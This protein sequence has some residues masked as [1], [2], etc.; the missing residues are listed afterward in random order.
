M[1][2]HLNILKLQQEA[3]EQGMLPPRAARRNNN[4]NSSS[5]KTDSS[6]SGSSPARVRSSA[7]YRALSQINTPRSAGEVQMGCVDSS[8]CTLQLTAPA[9]CY[10]MNNILTNTD[11]TISSSRAANCS[12]YQCVVL[13]PQ[14]LH[15]PLLQHTL[16]LPHATGFRAVSPGQWCMDSQAVNASVPAHHKQNNFNKSQDMK[17]SGTTTAAGTAT[18]GAALTAAKRTAHTS[19]AVATEAVVKSVTSIYVTV[20]GESTVGPELAAVGAHC[21]A[22]RFTVSVKGAEYAASTEI[23]AAFIR[24]KHALVLQE[25]AVGGSCAFLLSDAGGERSGAVG[26]AH[27]H[28]NGRVRRDGTVAVTPRALQPYLSGTATNA[29]AGSSTATATITSAAVKNIEKQRAVTA[30]TSTLTSSE[31]LTL[32]ARPA[33]RA[34]SAS[35]GTSSNAVRPV[36]ASSRLLLQ[37][38]GKQLGCELSGVMA[39]L[40]Q[41]QQ[42]QQQQQYGGQCNDQCD[43]Q[44]QQQQFTSSGSSDTAVNA[45]FNVL[46]FA[47]TASQLLQAR[48]VKQQ[49]QQQELSQQV[50]VEARQGADVAHSTVLKKPLTISN[51][52][53]AHIHQQRVP[54]TLKVTQSAAAVV[55]CE[56]PAKTYCNSLKFSELSST[57]FRYFNMCHTLTIVNAIKHWQLIVTA[58]AEGLSSSMQCIIVGLAGD[59]KQQHHHMRASETTIPVRMCILNVARDDGKTPYQSPYELQVQAVTASKQLFIN[60][61]GTVHD[62]NT[63]L[64]HMNQR[65]LPIRAAA[66]TATVTAD[67]TACPTATTTTAT[68]T[69]AVVTAHAQECTA[70]TFLPGLG[71]RQRLSQHTTLQLPVLAPTTARTAHS[72]QERTVLLIQIENVPHIQDANCCTTQAALVTCTAMRTTSRRACNVLMLEYYLKCLQ[73]SSSHIAVQIYMT[74]APAGAAPPPKESCSTNCSL[75]TKVNACTGKHSRPDISCAWTGS[76]CVDLKTS[77]T[78]CGAVGKVCSSI[79]GS[80]PT[81]TAGVCDLICAAGYCNFNKAVANDGCETNIMTSLSRCG[82]ACGTAAVCQTPTAGIAACNSGICE[83]GCTSGYGNC[84][85]NFASN[86]CEVNLNSDP[87]NC[88][89]CGASCSAANADGTCSG[90]QCSLVCKADYG[91]CERNF[92]TNGCEVNL[93]SDLANCGSCGASCSALNADGTCSGGQCSLVCTTGFKN[94]DNNFASN[95]CEIDVNSDTANCGDCGNVCPFDSA[96]SVPTCSGGVCGLLVLVEM[97]AECS[98]ANFCVYGVCDVQCLSGSGDCDKNPANGCE[99]NLNNPSSCG[100]CGRICPFASANSVPTCSG[101]ACGLLKP[102]HRRCGSCQSLVEM[103][104]ECSVANFC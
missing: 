34:H 48:P 12:T 45:D 46:K 42:Q 39:L 25:G 101:G 65:A 53:Y 38:I 16:K 63:H 86:G 20:L 21:I 7:N 24:A 57:Y 9:K 13:K 90:G 19:A 23:L 94:C 85:S 44:Q 14:A 67:T 27:T 87:A 98:V 103:V 37:R 62:V 74:S 81:C 36:S 52:S 100:V 49:P 83:L 29:A 50:Q 43:E 10:N 56:G 82:K 59:K 15:H 97:V 76:T 22:A 28:L 5:G 99:V 69:L 80:A 31:P 18:A 96:N 41:Q 8:Q 79:G 84:D 30:P 88:G 71:L 58:F 73:Y 61:K 26:T 35:S 93:K 17:R 66:A 92:A 95:G 33:V 54:E 91:N 102:T 11:T 72:D 40:Q 64:D 77:V 75:C 1:F 78:N 51:F 2:T 68:H 104:A 47:R 70:T 32:P 60:P 89:S 3:V 4:N 6:S 55:K